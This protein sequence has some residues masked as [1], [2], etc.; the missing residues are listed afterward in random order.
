MFD[1]KLPFNLE[2]LIYQT[3]I[4]THRVEFK[5]TW[6]D[7]IKDSTIRTICAFA[8]DLLNLNGGYII[9]GLDTDDRGQA[10][11]PP[12]GLDTLDVDRI[13]RE[14]AGESK[15]KIS[16]EFLPYIYVE[17][18]Q[19]K[20]ILIIWAPAGD[21][22]P[23][24]AYGKDS[25]N[26]KYWVR[27]GSCTVEAAGDLQRQLLE[28]TAKVP[29][30]DWRSL[31][32]KLENISYPLVRKYLQDINSSLAESHSEID[33]LNVYRKLRLLFPINEHEV[34]R[35]IALLFFNDSPDMFYPG[36]YIET[37]Q[38]DDEAGGDLFE[39]REFRGPLPLQIQSCLNYLKGITG[40]IVQK[41]P[42]QAEAE[43]TIPYPYAAMEE[44]IV[45]A[46]FHRGYDSPRD[47]VKIRIYSDRMEIT[48]YPGPVQGIDLK[49][50]EQDAFIPAVPARNRR[51]GDFLKELNLAEMQGTGITKIQKHMRL[52]GS[53]RAKFDFDKDRTY[54][55]IILPIHQRYQVIQLEKQAENYNTKGDL[56]EAKHLFEKAAEI[57]AQLE[58]QEN[59]AKDYSK[60]GL[61]NYQLKDLE[62]AK[63]MY[64]KAVDIYIELSQNKIVTNPDKLLIYTQKIEELS[65]LLSYTKNNNE[66]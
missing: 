22:R 28:Q 54:F 48:S 35:N 16:P 38:F 66:S 17:K 42:G 1:N 14:I 26:K 31:E 57:N 12:R 5:G 51:I 53:P 3:R 62:Q 13:Q 6:N 25:K 50:F 36:A 40:R 8:N 63:T 49:H 47:P 55:R 4:E 64:L 33:R 27:S 9:L 30:D 65:G 10:V 21:N 58:L 15:G 46:V 52:N 34:P 44:A 23:Y 39:E 60:L 18:F 37:A 32:G 24:A 41:I 7:I 45:N 56:E 2:N 59:I 43:R 29:F 61:I 20:T 19:E 11:L